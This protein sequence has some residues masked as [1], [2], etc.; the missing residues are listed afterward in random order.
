MLQP[1]FENG[2][3]TES[4]LDSIFGS[5]EG[6]L[7]Q[8]ITKTWGNAGYTTSHVEKWSIKGEF[9][10]LLKN[11]AVIL[12]PFGIFN[13]WTG[14]GSIFRSTRYWYNYIQ[15]VTPINNGFITDPIQTYAMSAALQKQDI[16]STVQQSVK[17]GLGY[18]L[19][20][21]YQYHKLRVKNRAWE[22]KIYTLGSYKPSK[23]VFNKN[24]FIDSLDPTK[25]HKIISLDTEWGTDKQ[26]Y[27]DWLSKEFG[28]NSFGVDGEPLNQNNKP[29]EE[30]V[31]ITIWSGS[32]IPI[33]TQYFPIR[34]FTSTEYY[35]LT[36]KLEVGKPENFT[37][38]RYSPTSKN[39]N[40]G[41]STDSAE[42]NPYEYVVSAKVTITSEKEIEVLEGRK[43]V[44]KKERTYEIQE[45]SEVYKYT[46]EHHYYLKKD[47]TSNYIGFSDYWTFVDSVSVTDDLIDSKNNKIEYFRFYPPI[48]IRDWILG[49]DTWQQILPR[50]VDRPL[51]KLQKEIN[52]IVKN[53]DKSTSEEKEKITPNTVE[54]RRIEQ[55]KKKSTQ[56]KTRDITRRIQRELNR[57][58]QYVYNEDEKAD[59]KKFDSK[60]LKRHIEYMAKLVGVDYVNY[61]T[62]LMATDHWSGGYTHLNTYQTAIYLGAIFS[63]QSL[64]SMEYWYEWAKR[65]YKLS[66]GE[67]SFKRWSA[68][69]Q[70]SNSLNL[71]QTVVRFNTTDWTHWGGFAYCFIRKIKIK[72]R[73]RKIKGQRRYKEILRGRPIT[74]DSIQTL[75]QLV[76]PPKELSSDTYYY[77]EHSKKEYPIGGGWFSGDGYT[78]SKEPDINLTL[79]NYSYTLFAEQSG[80]D[81][82]TCYAICGLQFHTK[83][84]DVDVWC[85]AWYDLEMEYFRLKEKYVNK[86]S[87]SDIQAQIRIESGSRKYRHIRHAFNLGLVPLEY[88]VIRRMNPNSLE[89]FVQRA[90]LNYT[91]LFQEI[92][93]KRSSS[94]YYAPV[95]QVVGF[96][97]AVVLSMYGQVWSWALF[98][99][100]IAIATIT[101]VA[102]KFALNKGLLPLLKSLGLRG[103]IAYIVIIVAMVIAYMVGSDGSQASAPVMS[104]VTGQASQKAGQQAIQQSVANATVQATRASTTQGFQSAFKELGKQIFN[105]AIGTNLAQVFNNSVQY[106]A[107][108]EAN[109]RKEEID[110]LNT[111]MQEEQTAL[112]TALDELI[113][114]Q[115]ELQGQMGN[116]SREAVLKEFSQNVIKMQDFGL[117]Y[118]R[119]L[120]SIGAEGTLEYL[121]SF[122]DLRISSE[123]EYADPINVTQFKVR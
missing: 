47:L 8:D 85:A 11:P 31:G 12:D 19:K 48:P 121:W 20:K 110:N 123:L 35:E 66:G 64:E 32:D 34:T 23:T 82:I 51:V 26:L 38:Y 81:E 46:E 84:A 21:Y 111:Q 112:K 102:V 78:E 56:S 67:E 3:L 58:K 122:L 91:W 83:T 90:T 103:I 44:K 87:E 65:Q 9:K 69:V 41:D 93:G 1:K 97:V 28:I 70:S 30:S 16:A 89:R 74:I 49:K 52:D 96:I 76:E 33:S 2:M 60:R 80:S 119:G 86:K 98:A 37:I 39:D 94:K 10:Q 77:N 36:N 4:L 59:I 88:D 115:E 50:F 107:Q 92:K 54:G 29:T 25:I 55:K 14:F 120:D 62:G 118:Q 40:K 15:Q 100:A 104:N 73:L 17:T 75:Q 53:S 13:R 72:G 6:F 116:F 22:Y 101:S 114:L 7:K 113:R 109:Y 105:Q 117:Q 71:P 108:L 5:T 79:Q 42:I 106:L 68:V 27:Q 45:F 57:P 63:N 43:L 99:K 18:N 61:V 95:I 24:E